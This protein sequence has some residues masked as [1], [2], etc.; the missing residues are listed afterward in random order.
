MK[1]KSSCRIKLMLVGVVAMIMLGDGRVRAEYI[2]AQ[3]A[4]MPTPRWSQTSAVVNGKIYVI[5]GGTSQDEP[6]ER[7]LFTVE[8]YDP[9]TDTWTP[10][11]DMPSAR[12]WNSLSSAVV[13]EKVYVIGGN[14]YD[15][16]HYD[17]WSST[18]DEYNPATDTWTRK[19]DMPTARNYLATVAVDGK[20]YAIGGTTSYSDGFS[21]VEEY[22]PA[23]DTWTRKS[24]MPIRLW[25]LCANVVQGKI[26]TLG[27]R[28]GLQAI[29]RVQ[30]YDPA[31]DTWTQ[32]GDMPIGTSQMDSVV[33]DDKIIVMG[34]WLWSA[35]LPY[36]IVQMYD[37]ETDIWTIE[38]NTPFL[39]ACFSADVVNNRI[40]VIGGTDKPHPCPALSTVYELSVDFPPDFNGDFR[41][42][43]DDLLTLI[44]Y[45]GGNEPLIDIA[46]KFNP[47]GIVN[48]LDLEVFMS[49]WEQ[50]LDDPRLIAHWRLDAIE[51]DV[52]YDSAGEND[53][54]ILGEAT[55][56]PENGHIDGALNF[57]GTD[58]YFQ[59]PRL[60][61]P[62][63]GVFSIFTWIKGGAPGQVILSQDRARDWLLADNENGCLK[64]TIETTGRGS[65]SLC[66]ETV[67]TDG[68]WHR[69][70]LM[71]DG[72]YRTLSVDDVVVA[73]DV[74]TPGA[75]ENTNGNLYL[76]V[77]SNLESGSFWS[78]LIDDV[79]IYD[80]AVSP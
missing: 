64:T 70:G 23:T 20:I 58:D 21:T 68:S 50:E 59:T 9:V 62:A 75:L 24:D 40:Y 42:D 47:D 25:G 18:V 43:V 71:W 78:G 36:T 13:D 54:V 7:L 5:G 2:W 60:L 57:D 28:P 46:P 66:S 44:E 14:I 49:Y 34:G 77:G 79:R 69:V 11:A 67:I 63:N 8:E 39:R 30:E 73:M 27:G 6:N 52:A 17:A 31:T 26:Y 29:P 19:A 56:A 65:G 15:N 48:A 3:K 41:I 1:Q 45:W 22:D 51:G 38:R 53:A 55:W 37:P 76:G 12:G 61:N 10:K 33:L 16:G 74:R 4:N 72:T 35:N 80:R 32:K